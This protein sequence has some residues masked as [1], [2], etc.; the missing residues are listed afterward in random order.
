ME[1]NTVTKE[2]SGD[3]KTNIYVSNATD[4]WTM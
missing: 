4:V 2:G 3:E 1:Q